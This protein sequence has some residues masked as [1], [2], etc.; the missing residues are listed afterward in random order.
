VAHSLGGIVLKYVGYFHI[1]AKD[2]S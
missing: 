2:R 1:T